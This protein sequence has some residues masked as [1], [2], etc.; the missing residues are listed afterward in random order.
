V[1]NRT[2]CFDPSNRSNPQTVAIPPAIYVDDLAGYCNQSNQS[3]QGFPRTQGS[4]WSAVTE[5]TSGVTPSYACNLGTAYIKGSVNANVT[6]GTS[7]DIIVTG[8]L[9]YT[10]DPRTHA[11]STD[12]VGLIPG[13]SAWVY[14]PVSHSYYGGYSEMLSSS[15]RVHEIDAAILTIQDSF[16]VQQY[17]RGSYLGTLTVYGSLAQNYRGTVGASYSNGTTTGYLKNYQYDTRFVGGAIQPTYFLKPLS[18]QWQYESV[19]DG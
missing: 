19:T 5:T 17:D 16:I 3:A 9:T 1:A 10:N 2:A 11:E 13:H 8:D 18:A 6:V 14:H 7:Q 12:I 4:G 15:E